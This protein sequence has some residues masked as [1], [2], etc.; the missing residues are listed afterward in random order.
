MTDR[1]EQTQWLALLLLTGIALYL[2]WGMLRPFFFVL[3]WASVMVIIFH[4]A[5]CWLVKK[6][7]RASLSALLSMLIVLAAVILPLLLITTLVVTQLFQFAAMAQNAI[8][9]LLNDPARS[10]KIRHLLDTYRTQLHLDQVITPDKARD[11]IEA[12]SQ[13]LL[14]GTLN[15]LGG[16]VGMVINVFLVLFTMYYLFRD[17]GKFLDAMPRVLP[18]DERHC[19]RIF[20]LTR[21]IIAAS[22]NGVMVIAAVQGTLGGVMFLILGLPSPLLWGAVMTLLST[23][24]ILGSFVVW[25]PAAIYLLVT[26]HWIKAV[27]L[28]AW[29]LAVV[30]SADNLLRPKLVG[31]KTQMHELLIFF[32]VLGGLQ[33]FGILGIL[34]GPVVLAIALALLKS[35]QEEATVQNELRS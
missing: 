17:G 21:E 2:C 4:P 27:I 24:P 8:Q 16:T 5:H 3:V 6:T 9:Q 30:G 26:G 1:K 7:G 28:T 32:S 35:F 25:V 10:E 20:T 31:K 29:G 11:L 12:A 15:V 19:Q 22:V 14:Q 18:L 23:I 34:L 13:T 33:A